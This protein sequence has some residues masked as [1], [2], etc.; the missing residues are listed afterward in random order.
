MN[1]L[2]PDPKVEIDKLYG[3]IIFDKK[4]QI[5]YYEI[6]SDSGVFY[7]KETKQIFDHMHNNDG[8]PVKQTKKMPDYIAAWF[9]PNSLDMYDGDQFISKIKK[10]QNCQ[11]NSIGHIST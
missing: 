11:I 2:E 10:K 1:F 9:S 8:S 5:W 6:N 3:D 7:R 4:K